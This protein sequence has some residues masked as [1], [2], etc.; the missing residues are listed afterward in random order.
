MGDDDDHE[1][2]RKNERDVAIRGGAERFGVVGARLAFFRGAS[3]HPLVGQ[4][5]EDDD[6]AERRKSKE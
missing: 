3:V 2:E 1:K 4:D 5:G 6:D